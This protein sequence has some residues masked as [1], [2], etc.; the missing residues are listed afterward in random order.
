MSVDLSSLPAGLFPRLG[1]IGKEYL[2]V[3]SGYGTSLNSGVAAIA[4]G[5]Q[6]QDQIVCDTLFSTRDSYRTVHGTYLSQLQNIAQRT[7]IEQVNRDAPQPQKDLP[8]ALSELASQMEDSS[9]SIQRPTISLSVTPDGNNLGDGVV[10]GSLKNQYGDPLDLVFSEDI[11]LTVTSDAASGGAQYR[12]TLTVQ[13]SPLLA[14]TDY[15]WPGGSGATG[16]LSFT[17]A[18]AI[19]GLLTNGGLTDWTGSPL[20]PTGWT[21]GTGVAGTDVVRSADAIRVG[22]SYTMQF[23]SNGSV[24]QDV[25]QQVTLQPLTVYGL[26][27]FAKINT[28][29]STGTFRVRLTNGSNTTLTNDAGD[30][31][32]STFGVNGGS[33][34]GATYTPVTVWF[35]TPRQLPATVRL[36][37]EM[38]VSPTSGRTVNVGLVGIVAAN[39]LYPGGPYVAAFSKGATNAMARGDKFSL[40]VTNNAPVD[41]FTR[42]LERWFSL[43]SLGQYLPSANSPTIPNSLLS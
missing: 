32:L 43:R 12:E 28:T 13:G 38:S 17:D 1:A 42:V 27:L 33:G 18:N 4:S 11:R 19:G 29:D 35:Q 25:Y 15:Q 2:R 22:T 31:L 14:E 36:H 5:F 24:L 9:D 6:S 40:T 20:T 37:L 10:V 3:V 41:S 7:V 21:I 16:T 34:I 26:T 30:N 8:T 23:V 39:Q